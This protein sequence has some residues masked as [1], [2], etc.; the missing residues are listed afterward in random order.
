[1]PEPRDHTENRGWIETILRYIPGFRGYLEK[2]YRR[3]SD[4]LQRDWLAD[5]LERSK[6]AIDDVTR[7]LADAAQID[8]LPQVDRLRG[9]LDKMI[10]RIRG[11][12]QGY[13]GFFDLVNV[14][15][16]LLDRIYEHD[17]AMIQKVETLAEA[18]EQLPDKQD[19]VGTLLADLFRQTDEMDSQWDVREDMLKGLE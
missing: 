9:R 2:E 4:D 12:M 14:D 6:R 10:G 13:S 17:V 19:E 8:L 15:E 5:R 7:A 16:A 1:M 11:A 18:V 3:E